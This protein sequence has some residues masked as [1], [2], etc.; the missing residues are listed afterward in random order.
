ML[1]SLLDSSPKKDMF[2][3]RLSSSLEAFSLLREVLRI[4]IIKKLLVQAIWR[5]KVDERC[6]CHVYSEVW[7]SY[8]IIVLFFSYF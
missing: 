3:P 6:M 4:F 8:F 2:F 1:K 5:L 7:F